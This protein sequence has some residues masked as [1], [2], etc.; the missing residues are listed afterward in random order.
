MFTPST[1]SDSG[2]DNVSFETMVETLK[3]WLPENGYTNIDA[4]KL[5]EQVKDYSLRMY[6]RANEVSQ[7]K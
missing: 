7:E 6:K 3:E 4:Q 2:D 1:K 5:A